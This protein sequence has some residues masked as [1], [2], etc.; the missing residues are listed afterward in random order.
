M[1]R[2]ILLVLTVCLA[3]CLL[4]GGI[5]TK[6][7]G[8]G[9]PFNMAPFGMVDECDANW[10]PTK[11]S[12]LQF[13]GDAEHIMPA[14][15]NALVCSLITDRSGKDRHAKQ[16]TASKCPAITA[17][18][19]NGKPGLF[20]D[21]DDDVLACVAVTSEGQWGDTLSQAADQPGFTFIYVGTHPNP[22][23]DA[24]ASSR[25]LIL[26]N[27][28]NASQFYLN[29]N[30][31]PSISSSTALAQSVAIADSDSVKVKR[32]RVVF[33]DSTATGGTGGD[34]LIVNGVVKISGNAGANRL[35]S[36]YLGGRAT[37]FPGR[38]IGLEWML[39]N[40][41]LT[42]DEVAKINAYILRKYGI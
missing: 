3:F 12:G 21:G 33:S 40:K 28:P 8:M 10:D 20:F 25:T 24:S 29:S 13:W 36:L 22:A 6:R 2:R 35:N 19:L 42:G 34:S 9:R 16:A 7:F 32:M 41:K 4:T 23:K 15:S 27:A 11:I 38:S 5:P 37:T 17:G 14:P 18:V 1:K 26:F 31:K 30:E 39:Y